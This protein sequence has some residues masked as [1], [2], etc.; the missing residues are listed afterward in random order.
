MKRFLRH[1]WRGKVH[2]TKREKALL[3]EAVALIET[4]GWWDGK[5]PIAR[6]ECAVTAL[7]NAGRFD[8]YGRNVVIRKFA[9]WLYT[10]GLIDTPVGKGYFT[11]SN[12]IVAWND[13]NNEDVVL[14]AMRRAAG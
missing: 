14:G 1:L 2:F 4:K 12:R 11:A 8:P 10:E 13:G 3:R 7:Q 9:R 5:K 6:G